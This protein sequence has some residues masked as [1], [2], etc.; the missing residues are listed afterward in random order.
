[1]DETERV[2]AG[3]ATVVDSRQCADVLS[4]QITDQ[5][6]AESLLLVGSVKQEQR[7]LGKYLDSGT[8]NRGDS[9]RRSRFS[10]SFMTKIICTNETFYYFL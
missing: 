9:L 1:M 8:K 5:F 7:L 2:G 4:Q 6:T 3:E 10:D